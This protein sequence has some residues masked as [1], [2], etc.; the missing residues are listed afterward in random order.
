MAGA[1]TDYLGQEVSAMLTKRVV[2]S[3]KNA[4][5]IRVAL[6]YVND[7]LVVTPLDRGAAAIMSLVKQTE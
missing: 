2:S 1:Q 6:G 7:K 3:F 5:L 4:E